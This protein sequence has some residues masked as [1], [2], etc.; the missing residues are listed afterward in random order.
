MKE[1]K[2]PKRVEN[3]PPLK[4]MQGDD[5]IIALAYHTQGSTFKP[6]Y[7]KRKKEEREG[8]EDGVEERRN[9]RNRRSRNRSRSR[10]KRRRREK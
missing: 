8:E 5:R 4:K 7:H 2:D 6:H 10:R 1:S 3:P 9:K